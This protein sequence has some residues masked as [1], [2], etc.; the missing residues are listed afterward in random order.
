MLLVVLSG[1][2]LANMVLLSLAMVM[3]TTLGS[4]VNYAIGRY[5]LHIQSKAKMKDNAF[6]PVS[7]KTLIPAMIHSSGLAIFTFNWGLQ[8]G[9]A[10]LISIST[11]LNIPYYILIV[12]TTVTFGEQILEAT[13]NPIIIGSA[14]SI[15][16]GISIWRDRK[17]VKSEAVVSV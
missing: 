13:D 3:A 9:S 4:A 12:L 1:P 10:W 8:R 2:T 15:W 17:R 16:L 6:K 11:L 14:L 5:F 7:F